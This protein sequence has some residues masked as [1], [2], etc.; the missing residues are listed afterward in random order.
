M[1]RDQIPS[2]ETCEVR[3]EV[4]LLAQIE[5]LDSA[6]SRDMDALSQAESKHTSADLW[7]SIRVKMAERRELRDRLPGPPPQD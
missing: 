5:E 4:E 1:E 3:H 7:T 2:W 6:I